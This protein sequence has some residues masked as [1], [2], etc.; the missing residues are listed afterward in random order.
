MIAGTM[1]F[2][3]TQVIASHCWS[4]VEDCPRLLEFC[5]LSFLRTGSNVC[6]HECMYV[7]RYVWQKALLLFWICGKKSEG[8][9]LAASKPGLN[10]CFSHQDLV[11]RVHSSGLRVTGR[12][13]AGKTK[14]RGAPGYG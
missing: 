3:G 4:N 2:W 1:F 5:M 13:A 6:M 14:V 10:T 9:V 11:P 7:D 8:R 12:L